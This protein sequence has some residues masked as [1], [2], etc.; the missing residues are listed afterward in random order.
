MYSIPQFH[1]D[2]KVEYVRKSRT[3]DPLLSV[4]EVLA[5]HEQMLREW[6]ERNQPGGG[7]IPEA[8]IYREIGSGETI[9]NR[10]RMQALLRRVESPSVKALLCVEPSRLTRGDLEDIGYLI[11]ILRYT[12]T[13]VIT[14]QGAYDL[15]D[16]RDRDQFER[17]LMRGNEYLEYTKRIQLN[18]RLLSVRNGYFIGNEAP[19]GYRK[20]KF[21]EGGRTCHTLEPHPEQ[22]PVVKRI[23]E[24]YRSGMGSVKI[25]DQLNA[26]LIPAPRGARW[27]RESI[28]PILA[29]EHYLGKVRWNHRRTV[30]T[31]QDGEVVI[32][33][34]RSYDYLLFN[35]KHEAIIDQELWDAVQ[36]IRG[37]NPRNT[38]AHNLTNPLASLL[39]CE[40]GKAMTGR[41]YSRDGVPRSRARYV[42]NNQR[43][44]G[45][46]SAYM[47]DVLDEV[48]RVLRE[49]ITDFEIRIAGGE[50]V[51]KDEHEQMIARLEKRLRSLREQEIAQWAEKT[52]G[53]MPDH[54]F[55]EL[56]RQTLA[57]IETIQAALEKARESMPEPIDLHERVTTFRAAL[58]ALQDPDAPIRKKNKLLKACI[59]RITYRRQR[60]GD[61]GHPKNGQE[62]PIYMDFKLRV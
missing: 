14:L 58:D 52:K 3:D 35:G 8:N 22:A 17:E 55:R 6:V 13:I 59:E 16:D 2:E 37:K 40:C 7:P 32:S 26:E 10:P 29:N 1:G 39:F 30:R 47:S 50:E 31:V 9:A 51:R 25:A 20:K 62:T 18:G 60:V 12:N 33:R 34:P 36:A 38:K 44:C 49:N 57:D 5:K 53:E 45:N 24:M 56:N 42:C 43:R 48:A 15:N 21:K 61:N 4:D 19:Y 41:V 23:F 28:P 11:K 54:V 27:A 46:A